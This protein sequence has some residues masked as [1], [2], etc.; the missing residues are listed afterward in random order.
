MKKLFATLIIFQLL[1]AA[2]CHAQ[3][4]E[5]QRPESWAQL[6]D[7]GR[8]MDRFL[9]MPELG[10]MTSD[11]WGAA[12]VLP[13]DINNGIEDGEWSYWGGNI[14]LLDD[15]KYHLF[16]CRWREDAPKGHMEWPKSEV[17]HAVSDNSFGPFRV[18]QVVGK[19]HNPEWYITE[20][21][22]YVIYVIDGYYISDNVNGPWQYKKFE[23]DTR[24]RPI[25]EG[26]SNLSFAKRE[27][28]SFIM[29]CR[30]GGIWI[31]RDGTSVWSQISNGTVYPPVDGRFEDPV[32]WKTNVQYH[33]IVNDWLGR[34]AWHLRSKDGMDWTIDSGEAY[35]PGIAV[36]ENGVKEDWFKYERMKVLQD[37]Y[38]RPLQAS[39][40]VI[41]TIKWNDLAND[42]HSSKLI[43]IPLNAEKL[44]TVMD[45]MSIS[46]KTKEIN[47]LVK[48]EEDFDPIND[49]EIESLK[50]GSSGKVDFGGGIKVKKT[51]KVGNDL[52]VTFYGE[53]H[54]IDKDSFVA[55]M[56]GKSKAG[57]LIV[58]YTKLPG[59]EY[60]TTMLTSRKPVFDPSTNS[61]MVEIENFGLAPSKSDTI[62]VY[63][64]RNDKEL[65]MGSVVVP[66][67][68]PYDKIQLAIK[69][70]INQ[71]K[72]I[73]Q[74]YLVVS[75]NGG[76]PKI[77]YKTVAKVEQR[78]QY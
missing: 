14:R 65:E 28:G 60:K 13:R 67:L 25:I 56:L 36:H 31:S 15:G 34:I 69:P 71:S 7:G 30:G 8:F 74:A 10:G 40:A 17:V 19:G 29:V 68:K 5:R 46:E 41:D 70:S 21:G 43:T 37:S 6:V 64:I 26:L 77:L 9:P 44:I 38:G 23:F 4:T 2:F 63:E 59:V 1:A 33:M 75:S 12:A 73:G 16:V 18:T 61:L 58:A 47:V 66:P 42:T 20:E 35:M 45:E 57:D 72:S 3:I 76:L 55:K 32:I 39:F 22:Q 50:F 48:A 11:T 27:D 53:G 62:T 54:G 24:D 49:L 51:K 52:L 78:H